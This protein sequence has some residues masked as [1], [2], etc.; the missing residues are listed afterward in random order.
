MDIVDS[1]DVVFDGD[2]KDVWNDRDKII[3]VEAWESIT[4]PDL[5]RLP[6]QFILN[7]RKL[8]LRKAHMLQHD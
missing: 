8:L 6:H 5:S 1:H 3:R 7:Y 2:E 4:D